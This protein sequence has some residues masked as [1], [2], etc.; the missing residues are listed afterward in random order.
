MK[1]I[2]FTLLMIP[3]FASAQTGMTNYRVSDIADTANGRGNELATKYGVI[4]LSR[5]VFLSLLDS[6]KGVAIKVLPN[7]ADATPRLVRTNSSVTLDYGNNYV[8]FGSTAIF[9]L[10]VVSGAIM[11]NNNAISV[12]NRGSGNLTV[13]CNGSSNSIWTDSPTNSITIAPG[14]AYIFLPDGQYFSLQ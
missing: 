13:K 3:C 5:Q 9:T 10:P 6:L 2:L 4:D 8:F 1:T 7:N 12:K 14:E 11:G